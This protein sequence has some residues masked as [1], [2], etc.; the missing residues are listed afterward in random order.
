MFKSMKT[1][2]LAAILISSA[3]VANA[4][5]KLTEGS[6]VYGIEY[7]IDAP[8]APAENKIK[9]NGDISKME[10]EAGP[11]SI[12][13]FMDLKGG[14]GL[15]LVDVPVAQ[16]QKAAKLTKADVEEMNA[17][18]P[19]LSE[20]KATGEKAVIAGYNAEKYTYKSDKDDAVMWL[21]TELELPL[22][23]VTADFKD[24]KGTVIKYSDSK[25]TIT[26]KSVS[27]AKVGALSVTTIP[28]GYDEITYA[29]LK[30]MQGGG[31]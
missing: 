8:G 5:K 25:A 20:F 29:E 15:V 14:T 3:I 11:A 12:G 6:L 17:K 23:M 27:D 10:I 2:V 30:A 9:F 31:E 24:V 18:K 13:V 1:G 28:S 22:N 21:T 4:Q 19:K 16:M 26:L 7:K